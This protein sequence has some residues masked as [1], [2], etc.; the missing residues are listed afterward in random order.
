MKAVRLLGGHSNGP[1]ERMIPLPYLAGA[2]T[3]SAGPFAHFQAE[4][5]LKQAGLTLLAVHHPLPGGGAQLSDADRMLAYSKGLAQV[6]LALARPH[7]PGEKPAPP[8]P[9]RVKPLKRASALE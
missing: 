7:L 5:A 8:G 3:F 4:K 1:V 9:R 6:V 2:K